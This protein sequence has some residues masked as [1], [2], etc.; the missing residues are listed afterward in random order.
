MYVGIYLSSL[1]L[2]YFDDMQKEDLFNNIFSIC[3]SKR[4]GKKKKR[5]SRK[6]WRRRR[7]KKRTRGL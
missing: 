5:T 6:K 1:M 4:P 3:I 2:I 7:N